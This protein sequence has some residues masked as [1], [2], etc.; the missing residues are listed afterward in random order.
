MLTPLSD[1]VSTVLFTSDRIGNAIVSNWKSAPYV[2]IPSLTNLASGHRGRT[3][4]L[5][6]G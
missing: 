2:A 5:D 1:N 4:E 6:S 3:H